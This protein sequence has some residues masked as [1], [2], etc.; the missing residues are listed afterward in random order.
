[1][2]L[3]KSS[4]LSDV[5]VEQA[6]RWLC[7]Q[8]KHFP[9]NADIWHI[10]FHWE[11][12]KEALLQ[13]IKCDRF[14]FKPLQKLV[15]SNGEVIHLW[16]S[17]DSLMLKILALSLAPILPSSELC[18]HI[19]GHGG[20]KQTVNDIYH[21]SQ[22]KTFVFRTDVQSYY[23]SI[24]H[25][26]LIDKLS[27]YIQDKWVIHLLT[28]YLKRT[29]EV[30]GNFIDIKQGISASCPLSP[31]I[32]SFFLYELDCAMEKRAVFYRRYMDD[33]IV[34]SQTKWQLR[35]AIQ[36]ANQHFATLGLKQHP[37]RTFIG[38][39]SA[40]FDFLGYQFGEQTISPSQRTLTNHI[41]RLLRL[42][43]QKKGHPDRVTFLDD[44][45]QRWLSWVSAGLTVPFTLNDDVNL[46]P[47]TPMQIKT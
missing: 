16:S 22:S 1:M 37:D 47:L 20:A 19:C 28:Q 17:I 2:N 43:E 35:R 40:G 39:I 46:N 44:Y 12:E 4:V 24:D 7:Q 13:A 25:D 45:R 9:A 30:G 21:Q 32:A 5:N 3:S 36:C 41:S 23:E 8:R 11:Q 18:T 34:L 38:R 42:Y 10:R 27:Y 33:I 14:Y 26:I 15:K 29:V 6:Y 31:L